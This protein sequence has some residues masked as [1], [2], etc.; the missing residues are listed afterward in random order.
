[1]VQDNTIA[2]EPLPMKPQDFVVCSVLNPGQ[3]I[4]KCL[5]EEEKT[6]FYCKYG[7]FGREKLTQDQIAKALNKSK[8]TVFRLQK[9]A[10]TKVLSSV[11]KEQTIYWTVSD[12]TP[13]TIYLNGCQGDQYEWKMPPVK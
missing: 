9:M 2:A 10:L 7:I 11:P 13:N 1:M 4:E 12:Y 6:A 3:I 8:S 5:S